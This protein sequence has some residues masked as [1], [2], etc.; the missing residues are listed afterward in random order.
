MKNKLPEKICKVCLRPFKW[1]KKWRHN[2][3]NVVY[4][5]KKCQSNKKVDNDSEFF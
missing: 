2:W 1:R 3:E 4:C 5:S